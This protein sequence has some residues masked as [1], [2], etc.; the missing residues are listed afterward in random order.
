M[1]FTHVASGTGT[2]QELLDLCRACIARV[3]SG[4][5]KYRGT[6]GLWVELPDLAELRKQEKDLQARIDGAAYGPARNLVQFA[7]KQE[8]VSE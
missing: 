2:D 6:D 1:A 8:A 4:Q 7:R 5:Q 3:L